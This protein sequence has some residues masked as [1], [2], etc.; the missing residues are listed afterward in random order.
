MPIKKNNKITLETESE[1]KKEKKI[2]TATAKETI[3]EP[4]LTPEEEERK[5]KLKEIDEALI[6]FNFYPVATNECVKCEALATLKKNYLEGDSKIKQIILYALYEMLSQFSE[7]RISKN[8]EYFRKKFPQLEPSQQRMNVYR[9]M[10]NYSTSLEGLLEIV[11]LLGEFGDDDS[12]KVLTHYFSF[13][14]AFDGSESTKMMRSAIAD[15]LGKTK[16]IYALNALLSYVKNLENEYLTGKII[17]S[18]VTWKEK[19]GELK[20]E[21]KKKDELL[22]KINKIVMLEREEG[23]YR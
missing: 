10:F 9:N 15:A 12:T 6:K 8:L 21:E 22:K 19:I 11:D 1:L 2:E 7:Y 13:L 16:S 3:K 23:Y 5:K 17:S 20:I 18:I 4:I 14:C